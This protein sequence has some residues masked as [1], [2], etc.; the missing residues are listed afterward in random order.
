MSQP[1]TG[2]LQHNSQHNNL[3]IW[4][5]GLHWS[6]A[7]Y[8]KVLNICITDTKYSIDVLIVHITRN[9]GRQRSTPTPHT[10]RLFSYIIKELG[11][12]EQRI[13]LKVRIILSAFLPSV[14]FHPPSKLLTIM[15]HILQ[16]LFHQDW[17]GTVSLLLN[18][19]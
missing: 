11:E 6:H 16:P 8:T 15:C 9:K 3:N 7:L 14:F 12:Q 5:L 19:D 17:M 4:T 13:S 2:P 18:Y 10:H 1:H